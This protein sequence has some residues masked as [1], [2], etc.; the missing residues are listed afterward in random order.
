[1]PPL[2]VL[3]NPQSIAV[4]GAS[5]LK[6]NPGNILIENLQSSGYK[7][8][9]IPVSSQ[10]PSIAGLETFPSITSLPFAPDV[11]LLC[12]AQKES[13]QHISLLAE[14][15]VG[16]TLVLT[17]CFD[18]PKQSNSA[19]ILEQMRK[20]ASKTKMRIIGPNSLGILLPW[21]NINASLS[22]IS[23]L[24][25]NIAFISQ[26]SSICTTVLDWAQHRQIGFSAVVSLGQTCDI[27]FPELLDYFSRDTKTESIFLYI[28]DIKNA[29][30]FISAG[31][32]V[33]E[34]LQ[35]LVLKSGRTFEGRQHMMFT[36]P[37]ALDGAYDAAIQRSGMLRVKTTHG[38]FGA[39]ETLSHPV[40]LRGE[41]LTIVSNGEGSA[42]MAVDS[43]IERGGKLARLD[44]KTIK[45]LNALLSCQYSQTNPVNIKGD[46]EI[47]RYKKTL[48]ILLQS[49]ETDAILIIH[50]PS[51]NA[52]GRETA[53][54]LIKMI[55]NNPRAKRYAFLT[56]WQ[57]DTDEARLGRIAFTN[58]GFPAYRTP[59]SAISA[60]LHLV[61]Y[62]Q[63]KKQRME[64]PTSIEHI[65]TD[66]KQCRAVLKRALDLNCTHL[67]LHEIQSIFDQYAIQSNSGAWAFTRAK[68][69][70]LRVSVHLDPVFG[71]VIL[72]GEGDI[73]L[74]E[75]NT[76]AN[77]KK[78]LKDIHTA[79]SLVPLNAAL[80]KYFVEN[81][82]KTYKIRKNASLTSKDLS[83]LCCFLVTVSQMVTDLPEMTALDFYP[84]LLRDGE[85]CIQNAIMTVSPFQGDLKHRLAICPY[86]KELEEILLVD[87]RHIKN[88]QLKEKCPLIL[89]PILPEDAPYHQLF[90]KQVIKEDLYKRFFSHIGELN[91]EALAHLTHIDYDR[92][93]AFIAVENNGTN[94][95]QIWGVVR[96]QYNLERLEG[97]FSILVRSDLKGMG[98]GNILMDKLTSYAKQCTIKQLI[99]ITMPFNS[100]MIALAKKHGFNID[101]QLE[102]GIVE[103]KI[104]L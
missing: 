63:N 58:A 75:K 61:E 8:K 53:D 67:Q 6:N 35:I 86:P 46:A 98:L 95:Q 55:K 71:P 87:N 89:R 74:G 36:H 42:V 69:Q 14:I 48:E 9:I 17:A 94:A 49:D 73:F 24:P 85:I 65:N 97:E 41:R 80:A 40:I 33:S 56:N 13:L 3:F 99:G 37:M 82:I 101:V 11:A 102:D 81:A 12:L 79:V 10:T 1:M 45:Q 83:A 19:D 7:G 31:R 72:L 29:R 2:D 57:G 21:L 68:S 84:L 77:D 103:M 16:F 70:G 92:E 28:N 39:L 60:F 50:A 62:R 27:D 66:I 30:A 43:F 104:F 47:A 38:L 32:A 93:M 4:I 25:G 54:A 5:H 44:D 59:E 76:L 20:I 88:N 26:S 22:P 15:G 18:D 51:Q 90:L 23:A 78:T 100:P 91:P 52:P 64:T 96:L 34:N